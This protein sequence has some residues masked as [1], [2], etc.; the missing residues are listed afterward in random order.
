MQKLLDTIH[1]YLANF[2]AQDLIL[3]GLCFLFF[4]VILI[5][6]I[7]LRK[8]PTFSIFLIIVG[9][10]LE[11][12]LFFIGENYINAT[13][14]PAELEIIKNDKLI[15]SDNIYLDFKLHNK[16]QRDF[17]ICKIKF[18]IKKIS[19]NNLELIKNTLKPLKTTEI[20]L[21]DIP[22]NSYEKSYLL[23]PSNVKKY[24][25]DTLITCF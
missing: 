8:L 24:T 23:I 11:F 13:Y 19:K 17:K 25:I 3:L 14:R 15:F 5:L 6:A 22:K 12:V 20:I 2:Y 9:I 1:F 10:I 7:F 16:S 21:K 4:I 18:N